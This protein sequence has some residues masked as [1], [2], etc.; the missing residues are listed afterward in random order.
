MNT[1]E[2]KVEK[3]EWLIKVPIFRNSLILKQLA[4]AIG[5][6]FGLILIF[7]LIVSKPENLI[8]SLYAVGLILLLFLLTY[9][10]IMLTYQGKYA[11]SYV[12]DELG[13]KSFYQPEMMKKNKIVNRL[14]IGLG[15]L[16]GK[17]TVAGAG[18]LANSK[19]TVTLKWKNIRNVKYDAKERTI[20]LRGSLIETI[21]VF[22]TQENYLQVETFIKTKMAE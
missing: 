3:I 19:Q 10:F 12:L 18:L 9:L 17:P 20:L 13:I 14:T 11:V 8:Y 4:V 2:S 5:I 7:F 6:P 21:G 22:C 1:P 16:A 15:L